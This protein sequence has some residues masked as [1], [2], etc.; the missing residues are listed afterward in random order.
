MNWQ[1]AEFRAAFSKRSAA[2]EQCQYEI[3]CEK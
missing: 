1:F 2:L 3:A